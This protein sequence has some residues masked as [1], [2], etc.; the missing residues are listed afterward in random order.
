MAKGNFSNNGQDT[1]DP[2]KH[3][4]GIRLQ[5]GVP[6]LDRDWN[7][8]ED[9]RRYF[10]RM[11]RLHYIG[12]GVPDV[13]GFRIYAS[14]FPAS[15]DF[16]IGAGRCMVNGYDV[17]NEEP[18]L[19]SEQRAWDETSALYTEQRS[20]LALPAL[21]PGG[22]DKLTVYLQVAVELWDSTDD[23]DLLNSQ[24]IN[25]ETCV[26]VKLKWRV[27]VAQYPDQPPADAYALAVITRP[28][29]TESITDEMIEDVRRTNLSLAEVVDDTGYLKSRVA[30]LEER[31][32]EI[33]L[34]IED[35]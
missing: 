26:R 3:Y 27:R 23:P 24:D 9:I 20:A 2:I 30:T 5:Q 15:D 34:E 13:E 11:L 8:L 25:L 16:M 19:Y 22:E 10:E 33:Q 6:L 35:I 32:D 17:C 28:V 29:G 18:V 12:Q 1:F 31:I 21:P 7:E 14:P 4:I